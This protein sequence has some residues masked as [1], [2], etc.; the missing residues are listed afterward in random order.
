VTKTNAFTE[1]N[2]AVHSDDYLFILGA[3]QYRKRGLLSADRSWERGKKIAW[4]SAEMSFLVIMPLT[5]ERSRR[6]IFPGFA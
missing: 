6:E 2:L 1:T 4:E 3:T 5:A